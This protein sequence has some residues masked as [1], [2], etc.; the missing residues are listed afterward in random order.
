MSG[1]DASE[2]LEAGED[3]RDAVALAMERASDG[4]DGADGALAGDVRWGAGRIDGRDTA[5]PKYPRSPTTS[6][7]S[8]SGLTRSGAVVLSD[9]W[10]GV[11][12]SRT[13]QV[14]AIHHRV[15]LGRQTS[16]GATGGVIRAPLLPPAT[17]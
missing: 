3:A 12:T 10:P 16:T 9:A 15:D 17:C 1:G 11:M 5:C 14:P 4:S 7:V 13:G 8:A 2:V 6:P